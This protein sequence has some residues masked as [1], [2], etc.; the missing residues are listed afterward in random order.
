MEI[1]DISFSH[2]PQLR[3]S[4]HGGTHAVCPA[5]AEVYTSMERTWPFLTCWQRIHCDEALVELAGNLPSG[6]CW[7]SILQGAEESCLQKGISWKH[8]AMKFP[9]EALGESAGH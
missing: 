8:S 7:K 4:T 9:K 5:R 6:T 2:Y 1:A 3:E